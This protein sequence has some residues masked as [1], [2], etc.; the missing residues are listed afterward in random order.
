[1]HPGRAGN[2]PAAWLG[3]TELRVIRSNDEVAGERLLQASAQREPID[4]RNDW[5]GEMPPL[6]Q[7]GRLLLKPP[8]LCPLLGIGVSLPRAVLEIS[9]GGE[10]AIARARQYRKPD[11]VVSLYL[12][13]MT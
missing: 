6:D 2:Q 7:A 13:K 11:V 9:A 3:Q 8:P 1:M 5:L 10:G 12:V 4:P